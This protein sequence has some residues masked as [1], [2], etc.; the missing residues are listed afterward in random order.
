[1]RGK[2]IVVGAGIGG[3]ATAARLAHAGWKV[4][5]FEARP[6]IGGRVG[7]LRHE[8]YRFDMGPTL[9]MM[10]EPLE[11]LF[12]DLHRRLEDYLSLVLIDPSYRVFFGD[13][14]EFDSSPCIARM[15]QE[16]RHKISFNEVAGYLRLMGDLAQMYQA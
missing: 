9:L 12:S 8:G 3:L 14:T 6:Q 13:G 1:M 7:E 15:V 10:L 11:R 5:V 16:I 4:E 2:A